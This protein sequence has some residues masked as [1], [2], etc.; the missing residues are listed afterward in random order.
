MGSTQRLL[1]KKSSR[2]SQTFPKNTVRLFCAPFL[3]QKRDAQFLAVCSTVKHSCVAS[4]PTLQRRYVSIVYPCVALA[5]S[6]PAMPQMSE[7]PR[8]SLGHL[9]LPARTATLPL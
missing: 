3:H 6:A 9:S 8:R 7:P 4:A 2:Q 1:L 5:R